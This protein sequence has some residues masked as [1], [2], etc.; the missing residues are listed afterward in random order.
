[1]PDR[2][3]ARD[4]RLDPDATGRPGP[5]PGRRT[6]A[7]I[8]LTLM[9]GAGWTS[10]WVTTGPALR[11]TMRASMSKLLELLDDDPSSFRAWTDVRVRAGGGRRRLAEVEQLD[12]AAATHSIV[13]IGGPASPTASVTSSGSR[14][15][16]PRAR[17]R[18][19]RRRRRR[20]RRAPRRRR[21][22]RRDRRGRGRGGRLDGRRDAVGAVAIAPDAGLARRPRGRRPAGARPLAA[23]LGH[24]RRRPRRPRPAARRACRR[25]RRRS[26]V[27][28][29]RRAVLERR[30]RRPS[31]RGSRAT[32]ARAAAGRSAMSRPAIA[33]AE[34]DHERAGRRERGLEQL[35]RGS[36]RCARP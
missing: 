34:Q 22:Q 25:P 31:R 33:E 23:G 5:S 4:R 17:S 10:Y 9:C 1:M 3:L 18:G 30:R 13:S 7:S 29:P 36:G 27:G 24:R 8:R 21:A 26:R 19:D 16:G 32:A 11:P 2:A 28:G 35:G 15:P 12:A 14:P 6:G 20:P